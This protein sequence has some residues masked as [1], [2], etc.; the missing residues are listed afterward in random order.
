MVV[1]D[2]GTVLFATGDNGDAG[3][4][5]RDYAQEAG[6]HLSKILRIDPATGTSTVLAVGVRNVQRLIINP[7][8]GDPRL[9]FVDL[10]GAVAEEFNSMR[11]ADLLVPP[12][13]NFGWGRNASDNLTREGTFYIDPAGAATGAA[14]T[15]AK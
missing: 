12:V 13:E 8:S 1:L 7:N 2:D 4:D 9:E 15:N 5:G 11:M 10:G 3:E 6:N 14:P